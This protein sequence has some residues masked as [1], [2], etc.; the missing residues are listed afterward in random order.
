M[1]DTAIEVAVGLFAV[2]LHVSR[3]IFPLAVI[4]LL[5]AIALK[6]GAK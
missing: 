4:I 1:T 6:K 3:E 5:M 2:L